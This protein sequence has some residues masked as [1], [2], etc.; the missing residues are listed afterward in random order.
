MHDVYILTLDNELVAR[1]NT[2]LKSGTRVKYSTQRCKN[3]LNASI[4][5]NLVNAA[6]GKISRSKK[7]DEVYRRTEEVRVC[8][9][10]DSRCFYLS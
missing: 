9:E 2:D 10:I 7:Y 5:Y 1:V 6:T 3:A 8:E 4:E